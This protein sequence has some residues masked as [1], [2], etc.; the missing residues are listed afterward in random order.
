MYYINTQRYGHVETIDEFETRNEARKMLAEYNI[1][2]HGGCYISTR[3]TK[4]WREK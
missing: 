2:F 3:C 1:A 4:D